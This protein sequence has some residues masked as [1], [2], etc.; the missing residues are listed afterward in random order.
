MRL[1][2]TFPKHTFLT[3]LSFRVRRVALDVAGLAAY[4]FVALSPVLWLAGRA[5]IAEGIFSG[6]LTSRTTALFA[7]SL[8]LGAV[9]M[10]CSTL[11]G[12][13]FALWMVTHSGWLVNLARKLYLAPFIIPSYIYAITW[14]G[15]LSRSGVI[16]PVLEHLFGRSPSSYGFGGAA[17]VLSLTFAPL[18]TL[19]TLY[20]VEAVEPEL[21]EM[22]VVLGSARSAWRQVVLPLIL[23]AVGSAAGLVF[24]LT[25]VEYGVPALLQYNVYVMEIFAEFSQS[26]NSLRAM[27]FAFPVLVLALL[28]V[29]GSQWLLRR[30]PMVS[31][32]GGSQP[33]RSLSLS[34]LG[35]GMIGLGALLVAAGILLPVWML[36]SQAGNPQSVL[37]TLNHARQDL[38]TSLLLAVSAALGAV[39]LAFIPARLAAR[40]RSGGLW[41]VLLLPLA[42]PAPLLGIGLIEL[43]NWLPERG[44]AINAGMLWAA[45]VGRFMPLALV[46]LALHFRRV[47]P[48]LLEMARL[49]PVGWLKRLWQVDLPLLSGGIGA[50]L[51]VVFILSLGELGATILVIPP[52]LGTAA[53][54]LFNL[55]HHGST[56]GTAELALCMLGIVLGVGGVGVWLQ[57]RY[58]RHPAS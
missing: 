54:R 10:V 19:F 14:M 53:L 11:L 40:V 43:A 26:G 22:A 18:V 38:F 46:A 28:L 29:T 1:N 9:V 4:T 45:H 32:P 13:G 52:G 12:L 34:R 27:A 3:G 36:L 55:L 23:P 30:T 35:V 6:V 33:L 49:H 51:V 58:D 24:A 48:L 8:M 56:Q 5:V 47:D 20:A 41:A 16:A 17:A 39:G 2:K 7:N 15:L 42:V 37:T 25:L 50:A 44:A 21:V 57:E 31:R